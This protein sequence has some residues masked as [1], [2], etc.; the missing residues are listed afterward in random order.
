MKDSAPNPT[1]AAARLY[2]ICLEYAVPLGDIS[3]DTVNALL[4]LHPGEEARALQQFDPL[5]P[6]T[7]N[8]DLQTILSDLPL[9]DAPLNA[10]C[11]LWPLHDRPGSAEQGESMQAFRGEMDR[12]Y[13]PRQYYTARQV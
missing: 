8:G 13:M 11:P 4:C 1:S 12:Q 7:A 9:L 5:S 3:S 6:Q 10:D 2:S